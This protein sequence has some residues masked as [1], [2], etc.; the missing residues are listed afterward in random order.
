[1]TLQQ[2]MEMSVFELKTWAAFL[3][4]ENEREKAAIKKAEQKARM[5]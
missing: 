5:R 3:K 2:G 1:M 4:L